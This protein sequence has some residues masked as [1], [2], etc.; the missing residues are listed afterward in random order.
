MLSRLSVNA[1]QRLMLMK[2]TSSQITKSRFS[3]LACNITNSAL[4]NRSVFDATT[5][6]KFVGIIYAR[7]QSTIETAPVENITNKATALTQ[8]QIQEVVASQI[9]GTTSE[10]AAQQVAENVAATVTQNALLSEIP[11]LPKIP[12]PIIILK[13]NG[14]PTLESIG[15]GGY[16]P[17]GLVQKVLDAMHYY[18][19]MPWWAAIAVGTLCVRILLFPLVIKIQR[20]SANMNKYAPE[21]QKLQQ[22][23]SEARRKGNEIEAARISYDLMQFIK[24]KNINP[25]KTFGLAALQFPV[26]I[27]F[28]IGLRRMANAPVESM[29]NGGLWWF[30]DLTT[31][32]PYYALPVITCLTMF[33]TMEFSIMSNNLSSAGL[34]KYVMRTIPIVTFPIILHFP[35]AMLCYWLTTNV[36]TFCQIGFLRIEPVRIW[37]DLPPVIKHTPEDFG[38][39]KKG[40]RE[41]LTD[42]WTNWNITRKV[43][44]C[45]RAAAIQF[46]KAGKGPLKRTFKYDPTKKPPTAAQ[47]LSKG[48]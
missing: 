10:Q 22:K 8:P 16:Y 47:I 48:K 32:D 46:N 33:L 35:G 44:D 31:Y 30:T 40:F 18:F 14:E 15:L 29:K 23:M 5:Y 3:Q 13:A 7:H 36:V 43:Q 37:L 17:I 38:M 6:S 41:G 20:N 26:F 11:E 4:R 24:T 39:K 34:A 12:E 25:L 42:S 45:E 9:T 19:E 27:S 2:N 28:I 21:M 1:C